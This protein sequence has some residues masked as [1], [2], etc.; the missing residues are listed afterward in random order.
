VIASCIL[1]FYICA[2]GAQAPDAREADRLYADRAN[3]VSAQ[4][5]ADSWSAILAREPRGFEAA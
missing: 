1:P 3:L 4:R 2:A 5:A